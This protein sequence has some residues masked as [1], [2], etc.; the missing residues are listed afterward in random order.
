MY[1]KKSRIP[2]RDA[3][4]EIAFVWATVTL[5]EGRIPL[6]DAWIEILFKK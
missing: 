1:F 4:I 5:L 3:W 2:L 6:R